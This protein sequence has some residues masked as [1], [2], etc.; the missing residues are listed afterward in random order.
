MN[1]VEPL[2]QEHVIQ[3]GEAFFGS[4]IGFYIFY[5]LIYYLYERRANEK[6]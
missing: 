4:A 6:A 3:L 2:T 1:N 5:E